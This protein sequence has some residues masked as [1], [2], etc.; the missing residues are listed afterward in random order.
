MIRLNDQ[1]REVVNLEGNVLVTAC[2][3]SGKTRVLTARV[4]KGLEELSSSKHRVIALTY[5]NR[6][7]D[8]I[9]S[10]LD[11]LAVDQAQLWAGTIHSFALE[12]ILRP[13]ASYAAELRTGFS[14][15][16]EFHTN[17][18]LREL[19]TSHGKQPF[20]DVNT[21]RGRDGLVANDDPVAAAIYEEYR[22][23]LQSEKL[24][25]FDDILYF[26][27][28]LLEQ[29]SEI[30]ETVG[31][32]SRLFCI[33][34]VQD[35]QDLQFGI[36]SLIC[37]ATNASPAFFFV[38]D[39]DQCIYESLGAVCKSCDEIVREFAFSSLAHRHLTGNYRST[40][41]IIDH[42][43]NLRPDCSA[44][45]SLADYALEPG[46][47]TFQNKTVSRDQL[48]A[49]IARLIQISMDAGIPPSDICVLAPHWTHVRAIGRALVRELPDV[50]FD[51]PGLSPIHSQR[52]NLWFRIARLF[53]T[54]PSPASARTRTRWAGEVLRDLSETYRIAIPERLDS[55]RKLLRFINSEES[56]NEDGLG[57]L[58]EVFQTFRAAFGMDLSLLPSLNTA[59]D[60]FFEKARE[61]LE[62]IES[63]TLT[64]TAS[65]RKL[66]RHPAG[67]VVSTCHGVK[68]EEYQTVI[69]FGLLRGYIPH[70][71]DVF[72]GR[73]VEIDR[74]SKLLFVVCSRAKK[75]LHLLA[76]SGRFTKKRD[77]LQTTPLL[78]GIHFRYD[79]IP[80]E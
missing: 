28:K 16:D 30:A 68:G 23:R 43:V 77:E 6:A 62:D 11:S 10:R 5:T 54:S 40:Q 74:A 31:H 69:A 36:L 49:A 15:A 27:Y 58:A 32:I 48:P 4:I 57:Y 1:Q 24:I 44:I 52:D 45:E 60:S 56:S 33:D 66:F 17:K 7:A 46:V 22:S 13:Y 20:F 8:E 72:A 63:D 79:S 26:A 64:D 2:P 76:E 53:L 73:A 80:T 59:H 9:Q 19:R 47:I 42:Y 65:F 18:I 67:I 51:A 12:W 21:S 55:P 41:R 35:T 39:A 75:R 29:S 14:V 71:N 78:A 61:V 37:R 25:D 50:D 34:E 38:G 70:W 3:G